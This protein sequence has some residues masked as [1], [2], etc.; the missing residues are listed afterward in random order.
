LFTYTEVLPNSAT[1]NQMLAPD[2]PKPIEAMPEL[3]P[4]DL[5]VQLPKD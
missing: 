1:V 2:D 3:E 5:G 4:N